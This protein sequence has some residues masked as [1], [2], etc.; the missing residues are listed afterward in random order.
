MFDYVFNSLEEAAA[1][2]TQIDTGEGLPKND[3][4]L[5]GGIHYPNFEVQ[6]VLEIKQHPNNASKYVLRVTPEM[7]SKYPVI[8]AA[9]TLETISWPRI[10]VNI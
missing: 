9:G 10:R 5:N 6:H 3:S 2:Q 8:L 4:D 7:N 1:A